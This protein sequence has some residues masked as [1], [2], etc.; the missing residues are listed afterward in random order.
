MGYVLRRW[1]ADRLPADLSRGERLVALELADQA[2]DTTRRAYS[3]NL[4]TT[5]AHRAGYADEKQIGAVLGKLAKRGIELRVQ[6]LKDGRPFFDTKG[7]PV[8]AC[9]RHETTY[10]IPTEREC[11]ALVPCPQDLEVPSLRDLRTD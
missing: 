10:K 6:L 4:L 11:A 7:R 2:N 5:V 3:K 8:F 9:T 1:L